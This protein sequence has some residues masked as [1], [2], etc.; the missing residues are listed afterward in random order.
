ML[1]IFFKFSHYL[2]CNQGI[3]KSPQSKKL[4]IVLSGTFHQLI[5][6]FSYRLQSSN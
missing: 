1:G 4:D 2:K 5:V 6:Y 3:I